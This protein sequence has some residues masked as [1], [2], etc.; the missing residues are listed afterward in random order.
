MKPMTEA[1]FLTCAGHGAAGEHI[2]DQAL[3]DFLRSHGFEDA[4]R[5]TRNLVTDSVSRADHY[6]AS[7]EAKREQIDQLRYEMR[8]IAKL[9]AEGKT[10]RAKAK[11]EAN[12]GR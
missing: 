8:E 6:A 1:E 7:C 11:A 10:D 5:V 9:I 2:I 3:R 4:A 12:G